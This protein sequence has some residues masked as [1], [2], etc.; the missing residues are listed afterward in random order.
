MHSANFFADDSDS[1]KS[2][3]DSMNITRAE[4]V[5]RFPEAAHQA[6][7]AALGLK[8]HKIRKE[9]GEGPYAVQ[10]RPPKRQQDD[11][12]SA[13]SNAKSKPVKMA[14]RPS[15][16]ELRIQRSV[17]GPAVLE[18][19]S[20]ASEELDRLGWDP[21]PDVSEDGVNKLRS[22]DP[23][24]VNAIL[25]ALERGR[26]KLKPS[27]SEKARMSPTGSKASHAIGRAATADPG[28]AE[29]HTGPNT[30]PTEPFSSVAGDTKPA[31]MSNVPEAASDTDSAAS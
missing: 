21:F 10:P 28:Q 17:P 26:L 15:V 27:E 1:S 31:P 18:S 3:D 8:Y 16:T 23:H 30:I 22:M 12:A 13:G 19:K 20:S 2:S 24:D 5:R 6:L 14:R 7:A 4:A 29:V 25:R 9:M 11:A